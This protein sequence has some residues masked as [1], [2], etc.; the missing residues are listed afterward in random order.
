M[1]HPIPYRTVPFDANVPYRFLN[2]SCRAKNFTKWVHSPLLSDSS[3]LQFSYMYL[4]VQHVK[5]LPG[6]LCR[7]HRSTGYLWNGKNGLWTGWEFLQN[8]PARERVTRS[9]LHWGSSQLPRK[10]SFLP[11]PECVR[12]ATMPLL[13]YE[14]IFVYQLTYLF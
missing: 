12:N 1:Y 7:L 11:I 8:L 10:P 5:T 14:V 2:I 13:P 6:A 9:L 4:M 3:R